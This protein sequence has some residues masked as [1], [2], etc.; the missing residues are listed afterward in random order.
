VFGALAER[1]KQSAIVGYLLA[2]AVLGPLL[3]SGDVLRQIA[4]LGVALLLF[5]IGL[6]FSLTRLRSLGRVAAIGGTLQVL[7]T[8]AIFAVAASW[9]YTTPAALVLGAMVALSSTAVVLRVLMART[10]IDSTSGRNALSILLLQD[11]AVVP[12][13]LLVTVMGQGG[14]AMQI[15]G[16]L[17]KAAGAAALLIALLYLIFNKIIPRLLLSESLAKNHELLILLAI[18]GALGAAWG[19][20]T[21][22][23][24]PA[25]GA[26]IAGIL[27]GESPFATQIRADVGPLRTMFVTLFFTSIGMLTQ[28]LWILEHLHLVLLG[29]AA[30][31]VGKSLIVYGVLRLLRQNRYDALATG[32]SLG[33]V[34]EFS[35]VI[36]TTAAAT[37]VISGDTFAYAVAVT[38]LSLF[39]APHMVR[40]AVPWAD[41]AIHRVFPRYQVVR[42]APPERGDVCLVFVIG[43]GPAGRRVADTLLSMG[44]RPIVIEQNARTAATAERL[45]LETHLG[46][47]RQSEVLHH[48]GIA[49]GC[50]VIVTVPDPNA[51]RAIVANVRAYATDAHIIVRSRYAYFSHELDAAGADVVVD[52]EKQVGLELADRAA[53]ALG[54]VA[55]VAGP[56]CSAA[57]LDSE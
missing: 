34:G 27:L 46:N 53:R 24:S 56:E 15:A 2:G 26:F 48:A 43:F 8:L 40:Y 18:V 42:D 36:A 52:E 16:A 13:V 20:H 35:F 29:V 50:H 45:G 19:A 44:Q 28:P 33:Q 5:S 21:L 41:A 7:L 6:E 32:I 57:A 55:G 9:M 22:G 31:F 39:F 37:G 54:C 3:F 11:I 47:A 10:Q 23:L 30:V 4:E 51:A 1:W 25:L 49:A 14:S 12:L 38:I 17:L